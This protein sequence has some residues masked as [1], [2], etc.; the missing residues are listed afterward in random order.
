MFEEE[1]MSRAARAER[2]EGKVGGGGQRGNGGQIT[3]GPEEEDLGIYSECDG[4][5]GKFGDVTLFDLKYK[6]DPSSHCV[7][8]RLREI[9]DRSRDTSQEPITILLAIVCRV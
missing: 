5:T 8:Q 1:Q 6:S 4:G 3:Q 7:M 9:K 2:V